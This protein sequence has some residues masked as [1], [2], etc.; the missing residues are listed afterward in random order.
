MPVRIRGVRPQTRTEL[1]SMPTKQ[2]LAQL[3]RLR[4]LQENIGAS[5]FQPGDTDYDD[6]TI[7]FFKDD[8]RWR[9]QVDEVKR[10]LATREH[11]PKAPERKATRLTRAAQSKNRSRPKRH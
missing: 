8:P 11:V 3:Q 7:I 2:L 1:E 6:T 9:T 5:D 4:A 10:I